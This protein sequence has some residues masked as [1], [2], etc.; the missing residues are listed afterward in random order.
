MKKY[1]EFIKEESRQWVK[2]GDIFIKK[3]GDFP[4]VSYL[5]NRIS[6]YIRKVYGPMGFEKDKNTE[7]KLGG[8]LNVQ[9][10]INNYT[11][12][13]R[14]ISDNNIKSAA[15]FV[16]KLIENFDDVYHYDGIFFNKNTKYI[17]NRTKSKGS[18]SEDLS[19]IKFKEFS[20]SKGLDI[21]IKKPTIK[22]DREGTDGYFMY[23]G[24][25]YTIQVK[26]FSELIEL[27]YI[28]KAKSEG[29]LSLNTNFLILYNADNKHIFIKN[30]VDNPIEIKSQYFIFNKDNMIY[31]DLD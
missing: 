24:R 3:Y 22:E 5:N 7:L 16:R 25:K 2:L 1:L 19:F 20:K 18:N 4:S 29:S 17:L 31:N 9:L 27:D 12:F 8:V 23:K 6:D 28:L 15:E 14:F 13:K 10:M 30:K 11:I 21:E 26:P